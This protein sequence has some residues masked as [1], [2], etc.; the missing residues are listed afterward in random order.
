MT[1][2][3]DIV[4]PVGPRDLKTIA[5]TLKFTKKNII[6]YRNIYLLSCDPSLK[7]KD[8]I[9]IDEKIAPFNHESIRDIFKT[10]KFKNHTGWYLQQLLKLY[11]GFV[12]PDMLDDYL[13]IDADLYF[14]KKTTFFDDDGRTLLGY[15]ALKQEPYHSPYFEHMIRLH[16]TL[17]R[18]YY[19]FSG[20]CHHMMFNKQKIKDLMSL[21]E[22]Y[23]DNK[24]FWEIL[25]AQ[26]NEYHTHIASGSGLSEYEI[27]FNYLNIY[28]PEFCKIRQLK[29]KNI[30]FKPTN[31]CVY[32]R[33]QKYVYVSQFIRGSNIRAIFKYL[34]HTPFI[35][36]LTI[37]NSIGLAYIMFKK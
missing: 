16:P 26:V 33:Y 25:I 14:L 22:N 5:G 27:Y 23:H 32:L 30:F 7:I 24:A 3:F 12:I 9:T 4:I 18:K 36:Y 28:H 19:E 20:V 17:I 21:V 2:Q 10:N 34:K 1:R 35:H 15:A 6:G 31:W 8:C 37:L 11:A 29:W 13:V